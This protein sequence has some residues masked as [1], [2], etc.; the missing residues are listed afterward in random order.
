M[1]LFLVLPAFI[2]L[3]SLFLLSWLIPAFS[4]NHLVRRAV[5][6]N[7]LLLIPYAVLLWQQIWSFYNAYRYFSVQAPDHA[8]H[9]PFD[10][11]IR[12]GAMSLLPIFSL[13]RRFREN[14]LF[15]LLLLLLVI[16]QNP[17]FTWNLYAMELKIPAYL[18]LFCSVYGLL[19]LL[20]QL[21]QQRAR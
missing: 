16:W 12:L 9:P 21:P 17:P 7:N 5:A 1:G 18:S 6:V 8:A 13:F 14:L 20:K 11:L 10:L 4:G 19:W 3:Q 15:S 2:C